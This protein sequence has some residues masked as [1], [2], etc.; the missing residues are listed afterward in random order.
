MI[1][2]HHEATKITPILSF[3]N[4]TFVVDKLVY[5]PHHLIL[6]PHFST[7]DISLDGFWSLY[8]SGHH[9]HHSFNH[10]LHAITYKSIVQLFVSWVS[11]EISS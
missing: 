2:K 1:Y 9:P 11:L 3:M 6:P 8:M 7:S 10:P 4:M 5:C